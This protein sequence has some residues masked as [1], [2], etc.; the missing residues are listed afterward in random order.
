MFTEGLFSTIHTHA[1]KRGFVI[2]SRDL[3]WQKARRKRVAVAK[4]FHT[5]QSLIA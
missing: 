3:T 2:F 5:F 1:H 4:S